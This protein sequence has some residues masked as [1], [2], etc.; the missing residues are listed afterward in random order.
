MHDLVIKGGT[1]VDGTG[2]PAAHGRRRDHR[3]HRHRGRPGRRRGREEIDADGAARHARLRRR[4]HALRRPGH[5]GPAAHAVVLAR[6]HHGRDGQLRRRLRAGAARPPRLADRPDGGRRGH[7]RRRAVE[8][9][10]WELGDA[11]PSTSTRST[12]CRKLFDVG[13]QVPH[14]AVRGVRDGGA[15]RARTSPPPPTT[16]RR[17]PRIVREGIEA[18]ALGFSTSRTIAH[19]AIDGEPVPGTFAAEDELFGIGR[20]LGELGTG[21]FEL[22]RP[23]RS[24]KTSP[25]PTARWRG[26][27]SSSAAIGRPVTFALTQN[28]HDPDAWSP[29]ARAVR[30]S[31]APRARTS[32]RRCGPAGDACCSAC[33]RSTRSPTARRGRRSRGAPLPRRSRRCAI[34]S[35]G[36]RAARRGR[37]RDRADAAVPR[38]RAR[39]SRWARPP[40][41]SPAPEHSVAAHRARAE[42]RRRWTSS[43]TC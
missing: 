39:C 8:G 33:R 9:I 2:A 43:T 17:W 42:P 37:R 23:A 41:T 35:C 13:A 22:A 15:R 11:S 18:G 12:R 30:R 3:R 4:A 19:M 14:G 20:V 28:D 5:L 34:P 7:P 36:A 24:A 31:R 21:V 1:V 40:T 27:A 32:A 6:R 29:H 26:C 10:E 38:P 16:S 25:R